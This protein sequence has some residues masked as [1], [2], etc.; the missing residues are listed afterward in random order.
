MKVGSKLIEVGV[1]FHFYVVYV[2]H[3]LENLASSKQVGRTLC[4]CRRSLACSDMSLKTYFID[5]QFPELVLIVCKCACK[6]GLK[7]T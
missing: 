6:D 7:G 1:I 2:I 5:I 3:V 4:A